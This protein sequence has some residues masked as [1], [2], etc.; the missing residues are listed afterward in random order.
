MLRSSIGHCQGPTESYNCA[1]FSGGEC[2]MFTKKMWSTVLVVGALV[3]CTPTTDEAQDQQPVVAVDAAFSELVASFDPEVRPQDDFWNYV[4]RPWI[5]ATEIPADK[6]SYGTFH[7]IIDRTDEQ[8]RTLLEKAAAAEDGDEITRKVGDLYASFMD[9]QAIEAA[10]LTSL[11]PHFDRIAKVENLSQLVEEF[12][13]LSA[14]NFTAPVTVYTDN[15]AYDAT[16]RLLYFWQGGLGLPDRSYYLDDNAKLVAAREAYAVYIKD[17]FALAN[18]T[19]GEQAADDIL[20]IETRIAGLQWTRLQNRNRQMIY[21]NQLDFAAAED[22]TGFSLASWFSGYGAAQPEKLVIAQK[23]YFDAVGDLFVDVPLA[24][25]RNYMR[26]HVLNGSAPYLS[27]V[28]VDRR[29]EMYGKQLRGQEQQQERWRRGVRFVNTF[30]GQLFGQ[31]YVAAY[32]PE[33]AKAEM[34]AM[35][36]HLREAFAASIGELDWMS[37]ATKVHALAKLEKFLPKL[38]YPDEW[39]DFSGLAT[40]RDDLGG[41]IITAVEFEHA[42]TLEQL[43]KPVD[44][45][46]W[47]INA[48]MVNAFYRPT[49]NTITFPAGI[50]QPPMFELG[51]DPAMNYGAIGSVIGHEFSHGFDDQGRKFDGDG[52]LRNWWTDE[53]AAEYQRRADKLVQQY[54]AYQPLPDTA[55]DGRLTLGENIGDLAGV[56]MAFRAFELSGHADGPAIEG[57]TPRQRFFLSYANAWRGKIRDQYL[58][59]L[60]VRDTH[61]PAEYRVT[62][63][64]KNVEAFYDAFDLQPGDGLYL[65]QEQRVKIW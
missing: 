45:S 4:N 47:N 60:L 5:E 8:T 52:L 35:V 63:I 9:E 59:E 32:F 26:F 64:I 56:T 24:Q 12:G 13:R 57:F 27:K 34:L 36:E 17:M 65:P 40:S 49:H 11:Q 46:E 19:G 3:S 6:S 28:F 61:S 29:F 48:H 33:E 50:L 18:W 2:S 31:A 54:N 62:G 51:R 39:R 10:G 22:K 55:I 38:G 25:W 37:E 7:F 42:Y 15:D 41:N 23:S 14:F 58:R 30:A 44:K 21:S 1:P 43:T 20:A 53:D 16:R